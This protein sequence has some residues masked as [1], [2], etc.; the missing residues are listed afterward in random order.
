MFSW[1]NLEAWTPTA[2]GDSVLCGQTSAF[3]AR[4]AA[5]ETLLFAT[6]WG[7]RNEARRF[8][9]QKYCSSESII[10][11]VVGSALPPQ[12]I[13][14]V[15]NRESDSGPLQVPFSSNKDNRVRSPRQWA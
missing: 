2:T 3:G 13:V 9:K 14:R 6:G 12:V 1:L 4:E 5:V 10:A 15:A 7:L 11:V 8:S